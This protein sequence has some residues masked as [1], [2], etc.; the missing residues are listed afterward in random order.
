MSSDDEDDAGATLRALAA[1]RDE[2]AAVRESIGRWD[3]IITRLKEDNIA[4]LLT[5]DE[6]VDHN[7]YAFRN[8]VL[9][10]VNH[11]QEARAKEDWIWP[12][13]EYF[14]Y[15]SSLSFVD[16]EIT[17]PKTREETDGIR[18]G[19][20]NGVNFRLSVLSPISDVRDDRQVQELRATKVR[21]TLKFFLEVKH[22]AE[23]RDWPGGFLLTAT[24]QLLNDSFSSLKIGCDRRVSVLAASKHRRVTEYVFDESP[25]NPLS[26]A[27]ELRKKYY[28]TYERDTFP[29]LM[30]RWEELPQELLSVRVIV[31]ANRNW[32]IAHPDNKA[33]PW[34]TWEF[35]WENASKREQI[36][37]HKLVHSIEAPDH[38]GNQPLTD[39]VFAGNV[40]GDDGQR[41]VLFL[42]RQPPKRLPRSRS[43]LFE[44]S[45]VLKFFSDSA[46]ERMK[47]YMSA[48][49]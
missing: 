32:I 35:P 15:G 1:I 18:L 5:R 28:R 13:S 41:H 44:S 26:V 6:L 48:I 46:L 34:I 10:C 20:E 36:C 11:L 42:A 30:H 27:S 14:I 19:L 45:K 47:I 43:G 2:I 8:L 49:S 31:F 29:V 24:P 17:H 12:E 9:S 22:E 40:E 21:E 16:R 23:A 38:L 3:K 25:I 4:G 7:V 39:I 37:T 33:E